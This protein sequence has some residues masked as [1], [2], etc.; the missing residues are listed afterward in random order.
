MD[1]TVSAV[2]IS[3]RTYLSEFSGINNDNNCYIVLFQ[4][5]ANE[6]NFNDE[7]SSISSDFDLFK[8]II[9]TVLK[10]ESYYKLSGLGIWL[11]DKIIIS[12]NNNVIRNQLFEI[13]CQSDIIETIVRIALEHHSSNRC[14]NLITT[15]V[16]NSKLVKFRDIYE[17]GK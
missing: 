9:I 8:L 5:F 17:I 12:C 13:I 6:H 10:Q 14:F 11:I 3:L 16:M 7:W 15:V 1:S 4:I 2:P